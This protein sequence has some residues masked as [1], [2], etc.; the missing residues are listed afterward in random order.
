[1]QKL[2][3]LFAR[4]WF[5]LGLLCVALLGTTFPSVGL[6]IKPSINVIVFCGMLL[7]GFRFE[8]GQ[9]TASISNLRAIGYCL[10][11]GFLVMPLVSFTLAHLFFASDPEMF[12]GVILAG[13][14]PTTQASSVIWTDMAGGNHALAMVLMT[15]ANI[16][17]VFVSPVILSLSLGR[18]AEVPV[19]AMLQ[20]LIC[21]I[22]LP[23]L[24]GQLVRRRFNTIPQKVHRAS[25]VV[26]IVIIWITVLTAL[27]SG[28]VFSLPLARVLACVAVQYVLMAGISYAGSRAIG[29]SQS[30]SIAVM[31][32]SAQVTM[33]FA[34]VV[35]FSYFS[36][37]CIIY[38]VVYHLFQQFM[39]QITARAFEDKR[40]QGT[41]GGNSR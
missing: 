37:R 30:D 35:G 26:S 2:R 33:T 9:L 3:E 4:N 40:H 41:I 23:T 38:V 1:M 17:G 27:S 15:A 22:L 8:S 6:A 20:T 13:A 36:P 14:V 34:A 16:L 29:L 24:L 7:I 32:C 21:F 39:G 5:Y 31:F 28:D 10:V 19:G 11:C 12:A 25:R 18:A